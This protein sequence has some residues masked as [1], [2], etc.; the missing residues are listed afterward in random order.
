MFG[1][2]ECNTASA[3]ACDTRDAIQ[4]LRDRAERIERDRQLGHELHR[5]A[6]RLN[7]SLITHNHESPYF[8]KVAEARKLADWMIR[9]ATEAAERVRCR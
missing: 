3:P 6:D 2:D 1:R 7:V 8:E 9:Q 5:F 4:E